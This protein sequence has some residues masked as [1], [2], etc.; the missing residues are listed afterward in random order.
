MYFLVVVRF[1]HD[2][3]LIFTSRLPWSWSTF[4]KDTGR[5]SNNSDDGI[6]EI[7]VRSFMTQNHDNND[8]G[9]HV[10]EPTMDDHEWLL[11]V[12]DG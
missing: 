1:R 8:V 5:S 11:I 12:N 6:L 9:I 3:M 2:L 4:V 10:S 7:Y